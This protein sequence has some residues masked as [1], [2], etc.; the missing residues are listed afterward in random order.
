MAAVAIG[1]GVAAASSS[2]R[3]TSSRSLRRMAHSRAETRALWRARA[4][5]M[6]NDSARRVQITVHEVTEQGSSL[7]C[8]ARITKPGET[9]R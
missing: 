2:A 4:C 7:E 5:D 1:S 3:A 8:D 6:E 9:R